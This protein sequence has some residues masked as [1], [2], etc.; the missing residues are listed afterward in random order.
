MADLDFPPFVP[1]KPK[2]GVA[3]EIQAGAVASVGVA[4]STFK[5]KR[6]RRTREEMAAASSGEPRKRKKQQPRAATISID[7][8]IAFA[9]LKADE[10]EHVANVCESI[11]TFPKSARKRIAAAIGQ[12]FS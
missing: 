7:S 11:N 6:K 8:L 4:E 12:L 9:G 3:A 1:A 10:I 2:G 5:P